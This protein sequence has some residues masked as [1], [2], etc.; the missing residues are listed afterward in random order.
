M[1]VDG[2]E[3]SLS[4]NQADGYTKPNFFQ[5]FFNDGQ[6]EDNLRAFFEQCQKERFVLPSIYVEF[7]EFCR[8]YNMYDEWQQFLDILGHNRK[9]FEDVMNALI[10]N[11]YTYSTALKKILETAS[12]LSAAPID[13]IAKKITSSRN[14]N[15][16]AFI[17]ELEQM[18]SFNFRFNESMVNAMMGHCLKNYNVAFYEF[19]LHKILRLEHIDANRLDQQLLSDFSHQ[20]MNIDKKIRRSGLSAPKKK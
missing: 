8:N 6:L 3:S 2:R 13:Y 1:S 18:I 5:S 17:I 4:S 7:Y 14:D 16:A 20:R 10:E 15:M 11:G 9:S 19:I 12:S